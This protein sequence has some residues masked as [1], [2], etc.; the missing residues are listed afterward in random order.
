MGATN[1]PGAGLP[2]SMRSAVT[3][4]PVS[5]LKLIQGFGMRVNFIFWMGRPVVVFMIVAMMLIRRRLPIRSL[6]CPASRQS[7]RQAEPP[8]LVI[9]ADIGFPVRDCV[10]RRAGRQTAGPFFQFATLRTP[11]SLP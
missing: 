1:L 8:P 9:R 2:T 11:R 6:I 3:S 4:S 5:R 10:S 7:Y